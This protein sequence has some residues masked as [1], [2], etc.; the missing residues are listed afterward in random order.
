MIEH[1]LFCHIYLCVWHLT[2]CCCLVRF[3]MPDAKSFFYEGEYTKLI[4]FLL[5]LVLNPSSFTI[6]LIS[7]WLKKHLIITTLTSQQR[8]SDGYPSYMWP[9]IRCGLLVSEC[10]CI[11]KCTMDLHY[12]EKHMS[13][14]YTVSCILK[15][16]KP[17]GCADIFI[18]INILSYTLVLSLH[19]PV[20][21]RTLTS[22]D[23]NVCIDKH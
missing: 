8:V 21:D 3:R 19:S 14:I 11:Y 17:W 22:A 4:F 13:S 23:W 15:H 1:C 7:M 6:V 16:F 10:L 5:L 2:T 12:T 20:T 18:H 9:Q